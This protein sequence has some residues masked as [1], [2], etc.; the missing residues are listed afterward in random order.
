MMPQSDASQGS[1]YALHNSYASAG[2]PGPGTIRL[3]LE[4]D[5]AQVASQ[6]FDCANGNAVWGALEATY[7]SATADPQGAYAQQ[8]A[9]VQSSCVAPQGEYFSPPVISVRPLL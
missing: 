5:G 8:V 2:A 7:G 3:S 9:L 6:R 1:A 4:R